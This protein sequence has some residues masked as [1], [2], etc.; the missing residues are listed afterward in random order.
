[1]SLSQGQGQHR[2]NCTASAGT[3]ETSGAA[4]MSPELEPSM[5]DSSCP[6]ARPGH[7][8]SALQH[9]QTRGE[10]QLTP[11][12]PLLV[13]HFR[14]WLPKAPPACAVTDS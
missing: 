2:H 9:S 1:M 5:G 7:G 11:S 13:Y 12:K 8:C 4:E 3:H 10:P 6:A 14:A